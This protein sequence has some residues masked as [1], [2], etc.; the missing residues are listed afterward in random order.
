MV[1]TEAA[2]VI[3]TSVPSP[4]VAVAAEVEAIES[5]LTNLNL[6]LNLQP[7]PILD[8]DKGDPTMYEAY[9]KSVGQHFK[10]TLPASILLSY[11]ANPNSFCWYMLPKLEQEIKNL[12]NLVGNAVVE[13]RHIVVGN[14]SS[15]L[16]QAAL[17]ALA[18]LPSPINVVSAAPF[19]SCYPQISDYVR[20][21]LFKWGGNA[22]AYVDHD[23]QPYIEMVTSPN[24][25]DGELRVPVV[26]KVNGMLVHDLAYYWPQYTARPSRV[27]LITILC[28]SPSPNAQDT[29]DQGSVKDPD[30]AKRMVKFMEISTIGV[31]KEA[32][33]RAIG[34]LEMI[35][36]NSC[37]NN[38]SEFGQSV[39]AERWRKLREALQ[40]IDVLQI[41]DFPPQHCNFKRDF[42]HCTPGYAWMK[43]QVGINLEEVMKEE[44]VR[45]RG[46]KTFGCP[47]NYARLSMLGM[48]N[49][50]DLLLKRLPSLPH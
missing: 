40:G 28:S 46:S 9:W 12:R 19:Y 33:L 24:N 34:V 30:V 17:Y 31:S 26:N 6:N 44:R 48:E 16:I 22:H 47:S 32:Q 41:R 37:P 7:L 8:F 23:S 43:A 20:S 18:E 38:F 13:G 42:L 11:F 2:V 4:F 21:G 10:I 15:Q 3:E 27:L 39:M 1:S 29:L 45:V 14:G 5:I 35:T 36:T 25:P 50:F 49:D